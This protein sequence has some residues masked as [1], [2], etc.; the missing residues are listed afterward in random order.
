MV[1]AGRLSTGQVAETIPSCVR[2]MA[3]GI[4]KFEGTLLEIG[5]TGLIR[6]L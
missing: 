5:N 4:G 3:G 2:E 1:P 6:S